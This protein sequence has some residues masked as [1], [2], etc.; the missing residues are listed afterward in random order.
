[1][2]DHDSDH[3]SASSGPLP[4]KPRTLGVHQPRP[5]GMTE[6]EAGTP[7]GHATELLGGHEIPQCENCDTQLTDVY[8]AACGQSSQSPTTSVR[9]FASQVLDAVLSL[10]SRL[11]RTMSALFFR[12]GHLT[13]EYLRGR[14]V[15]YTQPVQL[16]LIAAAAFFLMASYRPFVWIDTSRQQVV[17]QLP[18]MIVGNQVV[19]DRLRRLSTDATA[20]ELFA[21]RFVAAVNEF[22]PAFLLGSVVLFSL[23]VYALNF[24]RERRLLPHAVFA[25][26]WTAFY[27]L[28]L[29]MSRL[30]PIG[31]KVQDFTL[32]P[33][34]LY[35][36]LAQR[37]VYRQ[38][39]IPSMGKALLLSLTFLLLLAIWAQSAIVI[40]LLAV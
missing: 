28:L 15:R 33:G 1:M 16:Y 40:G 10:D 11:S 2:G 3:S 22:L 24:R 37:H 25:L 8:C 17:A 23:T 31:W 27:L 14:R 13:L 34:L 38:Q 29:T 21:V 7:R 36:T 32:L 5:Y 20:A 30:F 26:H 9:A 6:T 4:L 12:P 19:R 39:I 35:L 18:G